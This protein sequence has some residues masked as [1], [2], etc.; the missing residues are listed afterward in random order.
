MR[1]Y[2]N[3]SKQELPI[4][5]VKSEVKVV[6]ASRRQF[7]KHSVVAGLGLTLGVYLPKLNAEE[8]LSGPGRAGAEASAGTILEP[9]A[10]VRIGS[11]NMVTVISKHLEMGQGTYTGLSTLVAEEL[12]ADWSQIKVEGAP[13]NAKLYN[14][15]AWGPV[16]GTGGSSAIA[17]SFEQMRN[18]G[19]TAKAMIIS[20]A[21]EKWSVPRKEITIQKGVVQHETSGKRA[22]LGELAELASTQEVPTKVT[23]KSPKEFVFIGK[24]VAIRTDTVEKTNGTAIYTQDIQLPNMLNAVVAHAPRFG[25]KIKS[26]DAK[27][28]KAMP[29]VKHVIQIPTGVAV[30]AN[31]FWT[32]K[33][34]RETLKIE[35]DESS[36]FDLSSDEIF[37]QYKE[38]AQKPGMNAKQEGDTENALKMAAT[39]IKANYEFPYLAHATMEPMNC[40]MQLNDEGCEVWNGEQLHTPD[41]QALAKIFGI[42]LEQVK[43]NMLYA[44]GSFGRRAN[45]ASDYIKETATIVKQVKKGIPVKLV[46]TRE[47]DTHAGFYRPLYYHTLEAGIDNQNK[48]VAWQQRIVGQSI[49]A[50]TPFESFIKDGIDPSSIEGAGEPYTI[51]NISIQLHSPELPVPVQWWRS[52]G[53]T[54]TGY[55]TETFIDEL[56]HTAKTDPVEFRRGLLAKHPRH[57]GVLELAAEKANWKA[58]LPKNRGRGIAVV[59]SFDSYVAQVAEITL[60]DDKTFSVDRV[61]VAVDC[62]VAVN[63]DVIRAQ[64]E[65]GVGFG[66][67]AA[68]HSEITLEKGKVKQSNFDDYR[69][70]RINQMPD[71]EVHIVESSEKP[72]GVGEPGVPPIA[73]AVANALFAVTGNRYY[74]LPLPTKLS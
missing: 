11:D 62:G 68:L 64:M 52:V 67:A 45:P 24:G 4:S 37:S 7:L 17:N 72:T 34:A 20:A 19:A 29:G 1:C 36:A 18:A 61:V 40:V 54:H 41:Q 43:I 66:L 44:G 49:M 28:A 74:K 59:K 31:D 22:T 38:L 27:A 16:Q 55:A 9:N 14:N 71:V 48:A 6:N 47:D 5:E 58:S 70:L 73:P 15:L 30:L 10:F 39:V 51:P 63:P 12:D 53:H 69:V 23:L 56:A 42:K 33:Q 65:G 46:W 3:Q 13:A 35:W 2:T 60:H 8:I 21:A 50:G 32:A 26:F 25:S 57:L